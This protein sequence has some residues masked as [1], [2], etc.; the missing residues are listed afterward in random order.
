MS[1]IITF[2][3]EIQ[4][5]I[6]NKKEPVLPDR[7]YCESW[8]DYAGMGISFGCAYLAWLDQYKL[9]GENQKDLAGM[10]LCMTQADLIVGFNIKKLPC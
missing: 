1:N 6:P 2:D 10:L 4:K 5:C 9:Y 3:L 7:Q 8:K